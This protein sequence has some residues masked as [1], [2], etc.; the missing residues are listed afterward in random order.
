MSAQCP[1][2]GVNWTLWVY[3]GID[4]NDPKRKPGG[5]ACMKNV[6]MV[7]VRLSLI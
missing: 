5:T 2:S 7:M 3:R 6:L 1:L 4:A